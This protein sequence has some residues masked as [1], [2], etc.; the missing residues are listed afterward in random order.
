[1][2]EAVTWSRTTI[3][4]DTLVANLR[5]PDDQQAWT[6]VEARYG[7]LLLAF[8]RRFG[9]DA[10]SAEDARQEAMLA[11]AQAIRAGRFDRNKGRL[12]D[13]LFAI[14][15]N[16][17][18]DLRQREREIGHRRLVQPDQTGFFHR[19]PDEDDWEQEWEAEWQLAVSA[20]C[21]REAQ[22][23]FSPETYRL[24]HSS[25]IEGLPAAEVAQR[26][27]KTVNAVIVATHHVRTFLREIRPVIEEVF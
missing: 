2:A 19:V 3:D 15:R 27:G 6:R 22:E 11:F 12:R 24:F 20:Q 9:L 8:A 25:A 21:L 14:A 13:F 7:P 18:L 1:M 17:V 5:D 23:R 16:K 4:S 10:E 26:T